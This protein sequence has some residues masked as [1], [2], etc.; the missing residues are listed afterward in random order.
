MP[1][2]ILYHLA[3]AAFAMSKIPD[4]DSFVGVIHKEHFRKILGH[5]SKGTE[6]GKCKRHFHDK[7]TNLKHPIMQTRECP[8][9][10]TKPQHVPTTVI[11]H[12]RGEGGNGSHYEIMHFD[13]QFFCSSSGASSSRV[14][15]HSLKVVAKSSKVASKS[16]LTKIRS[17][18]PA[19]WP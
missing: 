12:R 1:I 17:K 16:A 10:H 5:P 14:G 15:Y 11:H 7:R 4:L 8:S 18:L 2:I 9:I 13:V 19:S 6:I 3:L